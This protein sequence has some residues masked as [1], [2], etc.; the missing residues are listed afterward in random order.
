MVQAEMSPRAGEVPMAAVSAL[1]EQ[2]AVQGLARRIT[3]AFQQRALDLSLRPSGLEQGWDGMPEVYVAKRLRAAGATDVDVRLFV[4][5]TAAMDRSRDADR[6][7]NASCQLFL[8]EPWP[9]NPEAALHRKP[10]ELMAAL[11]SHRVSQKHSDD[12]A[13]WR[14]IAETLTDPDLGRPVHT[15]IFEGRGD[16]RELLLALKARRRDGRA[17]FPLLGGPKIS[18]MWVRMLAYPGGAEIESLNVLPVAVDVQVRKVTEYLGLLDTRGE[19]LEKIRRPIQEAWARGVQQH[20]AEGPGRLANTASALDPALWFYG[21]WGCTRC[22]Q[23]RR[24]QPI[25]DICSVCRFDKLHG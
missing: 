6:L 24:R 5:F 19:D 4:T 25:S 1:S 13:A 21:K 9:Y 23:A 18:V 7:W 17:C 3:A 14:A 15:A 2:Q 22:E 11:R 20:G 12:G 10:A 16:A 8:E